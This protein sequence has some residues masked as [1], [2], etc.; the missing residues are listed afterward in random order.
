M[1]EIRAKVKTT[2]AEGVTGT[3]RLGTATRDFTIPAGDT[4]WHEI[5][6]QGVIPLTA[7]AIT[8]GLKRASGGLIM[9][10]SIHAEAV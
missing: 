5:R 6:V 8:V 10:E 3:L 2:G 4:D 9:A 7:S 1:R